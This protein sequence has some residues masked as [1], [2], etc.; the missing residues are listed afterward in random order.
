MSE[1]IAKIKLSDI[2][3]D[4]YYNPYVRLLEDGTLAIYDDFSDKHSAP[5]FLEEAEWKLLV[6]ILSSIEGSGFKKI[7]GGYNEELGKHLEQYAASL[8]EEQQ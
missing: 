8:L 7:C 6:K 5:L 3:D 2:Q 4:S 1:E